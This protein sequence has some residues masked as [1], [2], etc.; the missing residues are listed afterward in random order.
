MCTYG[1][2]KNRF[3]YTLLL[4]L[5][6][7]CWFVALPGLEKSWSS[8]YFHMEHNGYLFQL[9]YVRLLE[10]PVKT[11]RSMRQTPG[12]V[13]EPL[14]SN[15]EGKFVGMWLWQETLSLP[16]FV[17]E[18]PFC[19]QKQLCPYGAQN[20]E[21]TWEDCLIGPREPGT[22]KTMDRTAVE[23]MHMH[24]VK[25]ERWLRG[26]DRS[27]ETAVQQVELVDSGPQSFPSHLEVRDENSW[28]DF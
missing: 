9:W 7:I 26:T 28:L 15:M 1:E 24:V 22:L 18:T 10:L 27:R 8:E 16:F 11:V 25:M 14:M 13:S 17:S 23:P 3:F 4:T 19:P 2:Y 20:R 12:P 5:K 6:Q 21:I